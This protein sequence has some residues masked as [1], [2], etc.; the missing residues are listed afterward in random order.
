MD[1]P[2]LTRGLTSLQRTA[3]N[4]AV[5]RLLARR[6]LLDLSGDPNDPLEYDD[7]E[8]FLAGITVLSEEGARERWEGLQRARRHGSATKYSDIELKRGHDLGPVDP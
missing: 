4:R 3:G 8:S 5:G 1:R 7:L 2:A 6:G